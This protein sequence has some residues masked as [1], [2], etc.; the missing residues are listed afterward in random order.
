VSKIQETGQGQIFNCVLGTAGHI[1]HGKSSIVQR[2]TGINPDRLP[3]ERQRKLTIDLGFAPWQLEDGRVVGIIDVPGHERFIKNMV[4]G[5]TGIDVVLLAVAA[6]DGI[7]PQT[8]EHLEIL[9]LLGLKRGVIA[10]TKTDIVDPEFVEIVTLELEDFVRGTFL[11]NAA[12]VPI[13][14]ITGE[15][16][17]ELRRTLLQT[18][19]DSDKRDETGPF[20]MPVQRVFSAKGFGTILTGV[21][22]SGH[23]KVG[24]TLEIL[25]H[26]M[27]G[28]VRGIQAYKTK[29][30]RARAGHSTA[31]NIPDIDWRQVGRGAVLAS[32]NIFSSAKLIEVRFKYLDRITKPLKTR[33]T[34]RFHTGTNEALGEIVLLDGHNLESGGTALCQI[35]L[36][37]AIVVVPGDTFIL[38]MHSPLQLLGG[39]QVLGTSQYRLKAGKNFVIKR[40]R[41]KEDAVGSLE[42]QII[43]CIQEVRFQART[44]KEVATKVNQQTSE[45]TKPVNDLLA[46]KQL[47]E[48]KG[49]GAPR[50]I[51]KR[52]FKELREKLVKTID[53]FHKESPL[54]MALLKSKIGQQLKVESKLLTMA[55]AAESQLESYGSA[56]IKRK[57]HRVILDKKEL[58][59]VDLITEL[60]DRSPYDTPRRPEALSTLLSEGVPCSRKKLEDIF[61]W[62]IE[63]GQIFTL[64]DNILLHKKHH[65]V[66]RDLVIEMINEN[67]SLST[68]DFRG[69]LGTSRKYAIPIL[70]DFDKRGL[71]K[72]VGDVRVFC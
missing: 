60:F 7:M 3:E 71:T 15:G 5:A 58:K 63:S 21:P 37:E 53:D 47:I 57:Y 6:D 56:S 45:L 9:S 39:G 14:S 67:G 10:I 62:L 31:L 42:E 17:D 61:D 27:S 38:R 4:A 54:R 48:V 65:D 12:V 46:T 22:V 55:C 70:E 64:A 49:K 69:R 68:A 72:R 51:D 19:D 8:R 41:D 25:P 36:E 16:F 20:R 13:S 66:A 52:S 44:L 40:L 34:I 35:R 30:E 43:L 18:F 29:V 50:F 24:D 2:L 59:I 33:S 1:D 26:A 11:E 32:P 23:V 28:K